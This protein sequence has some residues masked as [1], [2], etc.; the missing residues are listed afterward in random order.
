MRQVSRRTLLCTAVAV[1]VAALP[2]SAADLTGL[3]NGQDP[4]A[5]GCSV[6]VAGRGQPATFGAYG[7]ADLEQGTAI[8]PDTIMEAGSIAKQFTAASILILVEQ[9]K[10]KL[11]D[12]IHKY[13]PE[14]PDYG[15]TV[16]INNLI[17]HTAGLR[18]W[19]EVAEIAGWP[20]SYVV[21]SNKEVME[22]A[23][24]QKAL[25]YKPGDFYLY[26]NTGFNFATEIVERVSG[27]SLPEF[28]Q[29][30]MFTPNG[31]TKTSWRTDFRA[32]VP[33]R[34]IAYR[35][36]TATQG[37]TQEMPFEDDYGH[38]GLLTTVGDL[39]KWNDALASKKLGEF[40]TSHLEEQA[41]LNNGRKIAYARGL[42]HATFH[43]VSEISHGGGTAAYKAWA[44]RYPAQGASVAVLCNGM[45]INATQVGRDAVAS[46]LPPAPATPTV[47]SSAA[48][49]SEIAELPGLY[50]DERTGRAARI[51]AAGSALKFVEGTREV[52][53][54]RLGALR[55]RNGGTEM[56][57]K[58]GVARM[59]NNELTS[60]RK[61]EAYAPS[62]TELAGLTGRYTS[63][64]ANG[65]L[66]L[67]VKD[68]K[69][70]LAPVNRPSAAAALMP[71]SRDVFKDELGLITIVRGAGGRVEGIRFTHPRVANLVFA[72]AG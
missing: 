69:L 55:Y 72:R 39:L 9:G 38:G 26:T 47:R 65:E 22:I 70:I 27:K 43:G 48:P 18:D 4:K 54:V 1:A 45:G 11:T 25:N 16:T 46:L 66:A 50:L 36:K 58:D 42:Q 5:P 15:T 41:V 37:Y 56:T 62:A 31:M 29:E 24:R 52:D 13:L 32:V 23:T 19:G 28:T 53:L 60:F 30:H 12:D 51:V 44:A 40:V 2:A 3:A 20:R 35:D 8:T 14:L 63:A 6:G 59:D 33:N 67:S 71:L 17:T 68:G 34:A 64:E 7:L 57:F 49:R 21:R 10:I 61:V